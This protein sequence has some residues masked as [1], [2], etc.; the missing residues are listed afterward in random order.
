MCRAIPS[1]SPV[2]EAIGGALSAWLRTAI[3]AQ[4]VHGLICQRLGIAI[5]QQPKEPNQAYVELVVGG[6][7]TLGLSTQHG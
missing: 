3:P 7:R 4:P 1:A 5:A 6:T 2:A